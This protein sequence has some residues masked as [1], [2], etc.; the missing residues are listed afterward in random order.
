MAHIE[1]EEGASLSKPGTAASSMLFPIVQIPMMIL[2]K[3]FSWCKSS[4][5]FPYLPLFDT[6]FVFYTCFF[7]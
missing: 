6:F 3:V 2:S 4:E 7:F 5:K 1:T